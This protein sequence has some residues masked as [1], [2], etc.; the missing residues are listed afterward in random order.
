MRGHLSLPLALVLILLTCPALANLTSSALTGRVT[1]GDAPAAGA[2]VTATSRATQA[3]RTA[4]TNAR[5]TYWIDALTPGLYDVTFSRAGLTSLSRPAMIE[6][7]RIARSDA[8]LDAS[9]DEETVMSTVTTVSVAETTA[10]TTHFWADELDRVP[11]RRDVSA[12]AL[13]SPTPLEIEAI[14]D[15]TNVAF[16]TLLG[17]DAL[18]EATVL[19]G[20]LPI[21]LDRF[22]SSV[23]LAR[24]RS[25]TDHFS[26]SLRDTYSTR[27]GGGHMIETTSGGRIVPERLWFF[28]AG[29]GGRATDVHLRKLR[30]LMLKATAQPTLSHH[31]VASH[32]DADAT[33]RSLNFGTTATSLRYTGVFDERLIGEAIVSDSHVDEIAAKLSYRVGDHVVSAGGTDDN[34]AFYIAD[35]WSIGR[36]TLDSGMRRD[37]ERTLPRIAAAFDLNSNR[38]SHAIVAS[39]GEYLDAPRPARSPVLRIATLGYTSSLESS[40]AA[41]IDIFHSEGAQ[42]MDQVQADARYRMFDRFEAGGSYTYSRGEDAQRE[43]LGSARIG[44]QVPVGGHE[45]AATILQR[46]DSE[47]WTTDFAVRY[48]LPVRRVGLTLAADAMNLFDAESFLNRPRG[49]RFWV[50]ARI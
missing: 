22:G 6:L 47:V 9:E 31:F 34:N 49:L 8:R 24:T 44:L 16:P 40:G 27:D 17:E 12:A 13:L 23:V 48:E 43:H 45:L 39:W 38:G 29:W 28:A 33:F 35:R 20:A 15:D 18:D 32:I 7:G 3:V 37:E 26:L 25:G 4:T 36:W 41:R 5:G 14:L 50:R 46:F 30:G 11:L 42:N 21:E 19:R 2:T 10:I 1:V